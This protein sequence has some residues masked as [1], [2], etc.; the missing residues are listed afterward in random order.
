MLIDSRLRY[1]A[2][3]AARCARTVTHTHTP[4]SFI[5]C[6]YRNDTLNYNGAS[7]EQGKYEN[8]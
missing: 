5:P 2:A 6:S 1:V 8:V 3:G 4:D 7:A